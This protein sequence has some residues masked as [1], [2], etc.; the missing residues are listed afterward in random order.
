MDPDKF[1]A[2]EDVVVALVTATE[3]HPQTGEVIELL[4]LLGIDKSD[5]RQII[6]H[7][8]ETER[9]R[10]N[11]L[12][13][14]T[15][16]NITPIMPPQVRAAIEAVIDYGWNPE[17][18][19]AQHFYD[20]GEDLSGHAFGDLITLKNWLSGGNEAVEDYLEDHE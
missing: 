6:Q 5:G 11:T 18:E 15:C 7:A 14:L 9:I 16:E 8:L 19:D 1:R 12:L 4:Y 20:D 17:R 3:E 2:Y 10:Y 13:Q